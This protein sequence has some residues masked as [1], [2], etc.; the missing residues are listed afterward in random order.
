VAHGIGGQAL[1]SPA[2][3]GPG[4]AKALLAARARPGCAGLAALPQPMLGDLAKL[5]QRPG[6]TA[7]D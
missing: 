7:R 1:H 3:D 5:A 4:L 6:K 2:R